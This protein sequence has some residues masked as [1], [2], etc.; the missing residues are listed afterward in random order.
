MSHTLLLVLGVSLG[1]ADP[2]P[3]GRDLVVGR[4]GPTVQACV[5][6]AEPAD[7]VVLPAGD[8]PGPVLIDRPLTITSQDGVLVGN[9]GTTL[10]ITSPGVTVDHLT[11]RGSGA[12]LQGPD[13]CVY[14][15]PTATGSQIVDSSLSDCLFGIWTHEVT[16]VR[17]ERNSVLGRDADHPSKK[18]NGIHL[19][20]SEE[21]TVRGNR[22]ERARDG[23][24]VSATNHSVI[25]D[26][27]VSNQRYGIHYMYSWHNVI[28]GNVANDNSGGIALMQS[29]HLLVR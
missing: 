12:D 16:G 26:N 27:V 8:W 18:G 11:V 25:S 2:G 10:S 1:A 9:F 28:E 29:R 13:V 6:M 20:D 21:L 14:F 4:D 23:I 24:Y 19:F 22:V 7:R 17:I 3:P 15:G 5:S